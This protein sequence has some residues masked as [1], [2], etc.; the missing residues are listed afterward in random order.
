MYICLFFRHIVLVAI[1][2]CFQLLSL[3]QS[4][5]QFRELRPWNN[6][7]LGITYSKLRPMFSMAVIEANTLGVF[8]SL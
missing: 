1:V 3:R 4:M 5:F 8:K 2:V 6:L 7:D